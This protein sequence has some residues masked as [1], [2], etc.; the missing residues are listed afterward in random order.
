[1]DLLIEENQNGC[2]FKQDILPTYEEIRNSKYVCCANYVSAVL[3]DAGCIDKSE[4]TPGA[5]TLESVLARKNSFKKIS[6]YSDL[7]AGDI[8]FMT[9][10]NSTSRTGHVQ[11][12]AG[13]S[14]WYNTGS[15]GTIQDTSPKSSTD[16]YV[17]GRFIVIYENN[18]KIYI[19]C[20]DYYCIDILYTNIYD[21]KAKKTGK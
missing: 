12:F 21:V 3:I 6:N 20:Y 9:R 11:I 7:K 15:T 10:K 8:V 18:K 17:K 19:I 2:Y 14:K 4:Y 5:A 16:S 13:N 1:M